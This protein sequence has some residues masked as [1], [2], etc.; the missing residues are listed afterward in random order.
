MR[1][2]GAYGCQIRKNHPFRGAHEVKICFCT[3]KSVFNR[4]HVHPLAY[5]W[6]R[7]CVE[8]DH[9][10]EPAPERVYEFEPKLD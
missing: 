7:H 9:L 4:C 2:Q 10:E 1:H 8:V 6:I 5:M 3:K